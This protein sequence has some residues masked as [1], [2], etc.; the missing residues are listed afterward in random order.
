M[1]VNEAK[2]KEMLIYFGKLF[3]ESFLPNI[4]IN[5]SRIERVKTFKLLGVLFNDDLSWSNHVQ[6][7]LE[8]V[9]RRYFI[10]YQLARIGMDCKDT[11]TV[12]CSVMR[13]VLE[14][15][16]V[17]WH[18]GLT[19]SESAEI[20]RVQKRVLRTIFLICTIRTP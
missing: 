13:S 20:E 6:F 17:V 8:K 4:V 10:I 19:A 14:Y 16:C 9:A 11:V 18:P 3:S 5:G 15:A 2:T 12:Y 1:R 7:I